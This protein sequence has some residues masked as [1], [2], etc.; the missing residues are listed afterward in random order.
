MGGFSIGV[1]K[2]STV[3]IYTTSRKKEN[4]IKRR[5]GASLSYIK[6]PR[7]R[8]ADPSILVQIRRSLQRYEESDMPLSSGKDRVRIG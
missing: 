2:G 4:P 1:P 8:A 5:N 3:H 6:G 7:L